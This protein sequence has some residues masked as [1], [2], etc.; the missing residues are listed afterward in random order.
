MGHVNTGHE[1]IPRESIESSKLY[2]II[3][4]YNDILKINIKLNIIINYYD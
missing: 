1:D 3:K 2:I 4:Y